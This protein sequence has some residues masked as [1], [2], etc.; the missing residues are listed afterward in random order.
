MG[1]GNS[2]KLTM[3]RYASLISIALCLAP[4]AL[5][6]GAMAQ[7]PASLPV[8]NELNTYVP[9][10]NRRDPALQEKLTQEINARPEWK[11]LV[12][13][14]RM[15][16]ALVDLTDINVPKYAA[17]NGENTV[18][19][20]SL[21]KIA[22]LLAAFQ[23]IHDGTLEDTPELR[24]DLK[25]MIQ[26]SSNSAATRMI[27]AVGGLD[28]VN[29]VLVNPDYKLYDPA[30]GGGLWVGKRYAKTG[31]R[32]GDPMKGISHAGSAMQVARF[33]YLLSTGRLVSE[34]ASR[35]MLE[36]MCDP[37][38]N[39]KFVATLKDTVEGDE[40]FRKS[41]SWR[42][43]HADSALV[44]ADDGRRYILVGLVQSPQGGTILK[45]LL[46]V[47]EDILGVDS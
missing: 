36:I 34:Q 40:M 23:Q 30:H 37:G 39:H 38:I 35:D 26:V 44:W 14:K 27:D 4:V 41:G 5:A 32:V 18:Y 3:I 29:A 13:Q 46:P 28:A 47:A 25:A 15:S 16:V 45:N 42:T 12:K 10:Y 9:V 22:I 2:G 20:A 8:I 1:R 43:Y 6:P 19:A 17:I 7:I 33:Y 21:P 11:K 24:A 31:R